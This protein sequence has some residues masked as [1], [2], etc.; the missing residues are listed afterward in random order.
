MA[1]KCKTTGCFNDAVCRDGRCGKHTQAKKEKQSYSRRTSPKT[2]EPHLG[3]EIECIATSE[4]AHNAMLAAKE[5]RRARYPFAHAA[6]H[7]LPDGTLL[8]DS[9]HCSRLNTNTGK[10]TEAMFEAV[11]ANLAEALGG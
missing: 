6:M 3:V 10:L 9:Y 7:E 11:V 2:A 1:R 8:A 5:L 4:H